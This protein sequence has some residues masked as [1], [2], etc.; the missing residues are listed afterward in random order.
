M[1]QAWECLIFL[2]YWQE[3]LF[4]SNSILEL[5][6]VDGGREWAVGVVLSLQC[7]KRKHGFRKYSE[8]LTAKQIPFL[9]LACLNLKCGEYTRSLRVGKC[10]CEWKVL[11]IIRRIIHPSL[12]RIQRS[13]LYVQPLLE[14]LPDGKIASKGRLRNT[15]SEHSFER[16]AVHFT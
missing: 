9:T 4:V 1:Q 6:K 13:I 15:K 8:S 7:R 12:H 16:R 10:Y 3:S 5:R 11:S 2:L 14:N